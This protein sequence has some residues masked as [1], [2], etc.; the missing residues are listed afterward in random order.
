[1]PAPQKLRNTIRQAGRQ[2]RWDGIADLP[3]N[4]DLGPTKLEIIW[5]TLKSSRLS[6]SNRSVLRGMEIPPFLWLKK[7]GAHR[8][9]RAI[10]PKAAE[11]ISAS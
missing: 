11:Q 4:F 2:Q 6:V 8:K 10:P 9:G 1:V 3:C 5:K 7:L